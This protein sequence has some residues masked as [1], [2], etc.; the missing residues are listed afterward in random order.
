MMEEPQVVVV[1][2]EKSKR[3]SRSWAC[4]LT[5]TSLPNPCGNGPFVVLLAKGFPM[6]YRQALGRVGHNRWGNRIKKRGRLS[7]SCT[8]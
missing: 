7:F 2:M 1:H 5:Y 6:Q 4:T 8:H 3:Q